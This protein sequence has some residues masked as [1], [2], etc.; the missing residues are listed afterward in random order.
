MNH[1]QITWTGNAIHPF[2]F[3]VISPESLANYSI[4]QSS[5]MG[6]HLLCVY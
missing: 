4:F 6:S 3:S 5:E 2:A 1:H